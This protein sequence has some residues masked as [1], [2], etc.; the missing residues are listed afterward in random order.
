MSSRAAVRQAVAISTADDRRWAAV[1]TRD[2]RLDGTFY[3]GVLTTGVFC[4]PSCPSRRPKRAN[5]RFYETPEA[6][7]GAGLRPCLRCRP[8]AAP[9]EDPALDRIRRL[10]QYIEAH[11][12]NTLTLADLSRRARMSPSHLQRRFKAT[13]GVSPKQYLDSCRMSALKSA[14]RHGGT[15][16]GVTGAIFQ[17]GYGSLSRVYERAGTRLGMTPMEYR[18]GGRGLQIS[19]GVARTP[20]G[21]LIVAATDR[22]LCFVQFG[23]RTSELARALRAEYPEASI[24]PLTN[25]PPAF[26]SWM[27]ALNRHLSGEVVDLRLPV[28]VRATSFQLKVWT[29][30]QSIPAGRVESYQ[31]V[32]TALGL[33]R[34]A[35]AVARACATNEVALVIPCHRVIR[36][37]GDL[38]GY[39]W[40]LSRKRTLLDLERQTQRQARV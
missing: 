33:P 12:G 22:G 19:Y 14:L 35:R 23:E 25:P 17:A 9:A 30:L 37:T 4:R 26:Q 20:L 2:G 11:G 21:L 15:P 16:D 28:H 36:A 32:A 10:C 1:L 3:Y 8:L 29:Y 39:R 31:D 5:V 27:A 18:A 38:A 6:A 24:A 34:G 7:R 40:G 13:V